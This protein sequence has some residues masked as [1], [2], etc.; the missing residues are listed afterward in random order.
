MLADRGFSPAHL[1][2]RQGMQDTADEDAGMNRGRKP[3]TKL[4]GTEPTQGQTTLS[5]RQMMRG[6]ALPSIS[7]FLC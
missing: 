2:M 7:R 1:S 4:R 5:D 6:G 3:T